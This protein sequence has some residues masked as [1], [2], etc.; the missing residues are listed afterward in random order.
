MHRAPSLA[1]AR[2]HERRASS[3]VIHRQSR[4]HRLD[5]VRA[6]RGEHR[7]ERVARARR[8]AR[9]R[10]ARRAGAGRRASSSR[11]AAAARDRVVTSRSRAPRR[12]RAR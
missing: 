5:V 6:R 9:P 8:H 4:I 12:A 11:D 1:I 7:V 10:R 3:I 2:V